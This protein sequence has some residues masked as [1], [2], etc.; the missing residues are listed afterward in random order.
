[1]KSR[2]MI[3][4]WI[5][6]LIMTVVCIVVGI[7]IVRN[8]L[9]PEKQSLAISSVSDG[10]TVNVEVE[11]AEYSDLT[12][13]IKLYG[14]IVTDS[15]PVAVYP[16]VSGKI[17]AINVR[18]GDYV[19]KGDVIG[20]VD[21]AKPG[22]SYMESPLYSP[23]SGEVVSVNVSIG[24][25]V[26]ETSSVITV[27]HDDELRIKTHVP[28]RYIYALKLGITSSFTV[29]AYP[30]AVYEA[31]LSYIS[32]TVDTSTRTAEIEL[33]IEDGESELMEGM[34][35]TVNLATESVEDAIT[36]PAS[37]IGEDGEGSYVLIADNGTAVRKGVRTGLSD[38]KRTA[39]LEGLNKGDQVIVSGA[40]SD[41]S[42]IAI[43][44]ES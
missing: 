16:D 36:V 42:L 44:E 30:D 8:F 11:T 35:A 29:A 7:L 21:Q 10:G 23:V 4:D 22:Y 26:Q 43:V 14:N 40:V 2:T 5:L 9:M 13:Y 18:R 17:S 6:S 28:E 3:F 34:F 41:G 15:E 38:G 27:R 32:P 37:A 1:M 12:S 33:L 19:E 24:D 31:E 20:Y 39:V 25:T